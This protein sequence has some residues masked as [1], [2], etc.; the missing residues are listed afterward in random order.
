MCRKNRS[1]PAGPIN[2]LDCW[3]W[4]TPGQGLIEINSS[5]GRGSQ[6]LNYYLLDCWNWPTRSVRCPF[7][8]MKLP[9]VF[10]LLFDLCGAVVFPLE[11]RWKVKNAVIPWKQPAMRTARLPPSSSHYN[12]ISSRTH[13]KC[14]Q[15]PETTRLL[16]ED[17][18]EV[19]C[20]DRSL[21]SVILLPCTVIIV[22][23]TGTTVPGTN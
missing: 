17:K 23:I 21:A 18:L 20:H 15:T 1:V 4:S 10:F 8:K 22:L 14:L 9:S 16:G 13:T 7:R 3:I 5:A 6:R 19:S 11:G 12:P 2:S